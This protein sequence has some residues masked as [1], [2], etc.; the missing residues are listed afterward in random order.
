VASVGTRKIT[1]GELQQ[2]LAKVP[3]FQLRM[4]GH[5][6]AEMRR[7]FLEQA[8]L[9]DAIL[10]EGAREAGFAERPEV[11]EK[12]RGALRSLMLERLRAETS[13]EAPV[14]AADVKAYY[15]ANASR[16][17]T[18]ARVGIWRIQ[19]GKR[20]Q[21]LEILKELRT[22]PSARHWNELA[23]EHS[24][25]KATAMRGGSLGYVGPDG[26]S[27]GGEK[28]GA[29]VLAAV[30]RVPDGTLVPEPVQEGDRWDVLFR[31]QSSKAVE[32]SIELET[33]AIRHLVARERA[34]ERIKLLLDKLRAKYVTELHAEVLTRARAP[35]RATPRIAAEGEPSRP[36][37]ASSGPE[38]PP[39][40]LKNF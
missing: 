29:A 7:N 13:T 18:P 11:A 15:E 8:V 39:L 40:R 32:R 4:L 34:T 35:H 36:S 3:A 10:A 28:V 30:A 17:K 2:R 38:R 9:H 14:S 6:P 33:P 23:R 1:V 21:A 12:V 31:D 16:F 5:T 26:T 19:V 24:L 22:D 37:D 20:E 27:S 25:D